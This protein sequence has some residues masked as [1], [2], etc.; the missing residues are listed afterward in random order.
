MGLH[1]LVKEDL[2]R[3]RSISKGWL[4]KRELKLKLCALAYKL[5][6]AARHPWCPQ[7]SQVPAQHPR[8]LVQLCLGWNR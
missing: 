8:L 4:P 5:L 3:G 6:E 1:Y 2:H 7:H